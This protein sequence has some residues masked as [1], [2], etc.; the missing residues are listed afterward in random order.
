VKAFLL[1]ADGQLGHELCGALG[2]CAEVVP[3]TEADFDMTDPAALRSAL[4]AAAADVVVNAAAYTDVDGAERAPEAAMRVNADA[5]RVLGEEAR[6]AGQLLIHY[7]TDFVFDGEKP[8]AYLEDDPPA[9]LSSYGR[10]KLGGEQA[11]VEVGAPAIVLRTAWLYSLR[12]KSFVSLM[13][14]LARERSSL[15]VV[16]DQIGSPTFCRDLA[17]ATA[18]LLYGL[19]S[20]SAAERQAAYGVYHLAGGGACSRYELAQA[21]FELDPGR[22]EHKLRELEPISSDAYPLPAARPKRAPLDCS[23]ARRQFG[24]A[25]PPWR[26]SLARALR[27]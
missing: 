8:T 14:K 15:R 1:G 2:C 13:L 22:A 23:K 25:L 27:S 19:H 3:A 24:I 18:L 26:E 10:S 12:R 21:V 4:Q 16:D 17:Q 5:V 11:L 9:P 6:R 7:S 20:A